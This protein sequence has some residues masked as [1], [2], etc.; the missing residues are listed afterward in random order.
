MHT[1]PC[2]R[3]CGASDQILF[4]THKRLLTSNEAEMVQLPVQALLHEAGVYP[5]APGSSADA[6]PVDPVKWEYFKKWF[7]KALNV[8]LHVSAPSSPHQAMHF[9]AQEMY[10]HSVADVDATATA[11][12]GALDVVRRLT[13]EQAATFQALHRIASSAWAVRGTP[14]RLRLQSTTCLLTG[15]RMRARRWGGCGR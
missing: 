4:A 13:S 11:Q 10:A 8:L 3:G 6:F 5:G 15:K 12:K 2:M 1:L 14:A 7:L 9:S